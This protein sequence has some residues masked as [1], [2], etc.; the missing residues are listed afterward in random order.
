M[1]WGLGLFEVLTVGQDF[2]VTQLQLSRV[3]AQARRLRRMSWCVMVVVVSDDRTFLAS[4][5]EWS[6]KGRLLVWSTRL[7]VVTRLPREDLVLILSSFW[8][9]SM[10]NAMMLNAEQSSNS[11]SFHGGRINV[12]ALPYEPYWISANE[13]NNTKY[14]GID[15]NQL[16]T[17]ADALNFTFHVLPSNNWAEDHKVPLPRRQSTAQNTGHSKAPHTNETTSPDTRC[18]PGKRRT[19]ENKPPVQ[20]PAGVAQGKEGLKKINHQSRYQL[21]LPKEKK[22]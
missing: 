10:T 11:L 14:S 5:A 1:T 7:L 9:F 4:F 6:L 8:T 17:L 12:T 19:K 13:D 21:V 15:Y 2:N 22:D 16:V 18:C 3:V 20:I